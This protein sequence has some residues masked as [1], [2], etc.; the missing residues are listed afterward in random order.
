MCAQSVGDALSVV[1]EAIN[2]AGIL[3][4]RIRCCE[5]LFLGC[6]S[7]NVT[8]VYLADTPGHGTT[9]RRTDLQDASY[10]IWIYL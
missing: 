5:A 2:R 6:P 8:H 9:I 10:F 3:G 7:V 1:P 4:I